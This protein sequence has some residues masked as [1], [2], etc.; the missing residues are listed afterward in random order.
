MKPLFAFILLLAGFS[1]KSQDGNFFL[2]HYTPNEE[3]AGSVTFS[4]AQDYKGVIYF[5]N[6]NGVLEFDGRNWGITPTP[7]PIFTIISNGNQVFAGGYK[8]FGK[9]VLGGDNLRTYQSI[10]DGVANSDQIIS[11]VSL[12]DKIYF[13]NHQNIFV[14]S[15]TSGKIES[16]LPVT[17]KGDEWNNLF[18]I[19]DN[20][21]A[22]SSN[23]FFKLE[24]G[25][26]VSSD[27]SIP[28]GETIEFSSAFENKSAFLTSGSRLFVKDADAFKEVILNDQ[29]IIQQYAATSLEWVSE[30]LVAIGTL[31]NGIYFIDVK[32]G[33]TRENTN[34]FTGLP[35]NEVYALLGDGIQGLWVAHAYGFTRVA[36]SLPFHSY[37][38]YPGLNGNLLCAKTFQGITYVGTTLG[39][40]ALTASETERTITKTIDTEG[41]QVTKSKTSGLFSF[42]RKKRL[43]PAD[44]NSQKEIVGKKASVKTKSY[45]YRKVEGLDSKVTQLIEYNGQ[46]LAS[47][48][49]GIASVSGFGSKSLWNSP[50]HFIFI[51]PTLNQLLIST[52][53]DEVRTFIFGGTLKETH[54]LDT[55]NE[56]VS[57]MFEDKL[58]NIWLCSRSNII[59]VETVDS[60]ITS[61]EEIP[62]VNPTFEESVGLAYGSEVYVAAA[63][64]FNRF[65]ISK[66]IFEKYDSFPGPKRYF[67]SAGYFWF[68][69]GHR[70][71]TVDQR[72]QSNLKLEWLGLF[73][74]LR[75]ISPA[76][77]S[78]SLWIITAENELY[79]FAPKNSDVSKVGYPLFLKEVRGQKSKFAPSKSVRISQLES[80]VAFEFIQPDYLGMRAVEYRYWVRGLSKDWTAW[81]S[82]NNIVN[83]SYLPTGSYKLEVQTR[84]L[85]GKVSQVEQI[86]LVVEPPYWQ[87]WWFYLLEVVFFG[88]LV[89]LSIRLSGGNPKY[90]MI[91]QVLSLLTVI[92]LI[93]LAQTIVTSYITL[94]ATPVLDFFLQV[95]IA[96]LV[97]PLENMLTRFITRENKSV[98]VS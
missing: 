19:A 54:L 76:S 28:K 43:T 51:S 25:K 20:V 97:L 9:I 78:E 87:R 17:E 70:W 77:N 41:K 13:C 52:L 53:D 96:L 38:H 90:R 89:F 81:S 23:G 58:Q 30:S 45:V 48:N 91:S 4:M 67:A 10:T 44:A 47:G 49:F 7:G 11:S 80:T 42:L 56:Y 33:S 46:L 69:D 72:L 39:L 75:Y 2:S 26:I 50:V 14:Y 22:K 86:S 27:L 95:G 98:S 16:T 3:W 84:D 35:D 15:V 73:P 12:K 34:F 40:Y 21:Y 31:R 6:N 71:R 57:Y 18:H 85:M 59:K 94:K 66:N 37:S 68:H 55:L 74:N 64:S 63:G 29:S 93:Q 8:G 92:M 36:P 1:L 61:V 5:A 88:T 60:K 32:T 82:D 79:H 24:N 62:F 65:N 83:F